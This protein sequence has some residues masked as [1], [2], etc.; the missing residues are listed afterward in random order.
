MIL[1]S[2]IYFLL[3]IAFTIGI[4]QIH[5]AK[6]KN[7]QNI[8]V[9][10][11][12][13][14]EEKFLPG[15]LAKLIQQNYPVDK[16]EII[17]AD[18]RSTDRTAKIVHDFQQKFPNIK[19]LHIEKEN[20]HLLGKK[21]A[22]Q[23]AIE[24]ASNE[25]LAFTDADCLPSKNWLREINLHFTKNIDYLAGYSPLLLSPSF[26]FY[27]KNLERAS[28]FAVV[29]GSIGLGWLITSS[30]RNIAYRKSVFQKSEGFSEIGH[31][32]SGDDDLLLQKMAK[33]IRK[34]GFIFSKDA[35]VPSRDKEN[36]KE[37]LDLESRRASKWKYYPLSVQLMTLFIFLYYLI[38]ATY[39]LI[40]LFKLDFSS[41]FWLNLFL[42][43]GS[44]FLLLMTFLSKTHKLRYLAFFPLAE[45]FYIPYFIFFG[46][47]GTFGKYRWK[48]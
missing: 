24:S 7:I 10:I 20:P 31:I 23:K 3:I 18:D 28:H 25:I 11:A 41:I 29:A 45:L 36:K 19:Y 12:A 6:N 14:N 22:L 1:L 32:R 47:K 42:K 34:A 44:E 37:M 40:H 46:L 30:A 9:I 2:S 5:H 16:F 4:L 48:N 35:I 43:I 13:R 38:F 21:G 39:F 26:F 33:N 15:L 17:I 8:S 27:L